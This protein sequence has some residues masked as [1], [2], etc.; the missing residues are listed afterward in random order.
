MSTD[1]AGEGGVGGAVRQARAYRGRFDRG[2][3][4]EQGN[5]K[6]FRGHGGVGRGI[7]RLRSGC[8]GV[9]E[10]GRHELLRVQGLDRRYKLV[11]CA[12]NVFGG[13]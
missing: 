9:D 3:G 11:R 4:R 12:E 5:S 13:D 10:E 1:E 6:L 2:G 8:V 7:G